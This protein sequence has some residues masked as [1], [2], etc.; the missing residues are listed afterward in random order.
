MTKEEAQNLKSFDH[1]CTCGGST[2]F[3]NGRNP[4]QPHMEW[5]PQL[6]QWLEWKAALLKEKK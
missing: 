6:P 1:Y 3:N 5:C 4:D 2:C